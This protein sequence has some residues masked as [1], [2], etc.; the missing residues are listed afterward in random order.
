LHTVHMITLST[1][2][3]AISSAVTVIAHTKDGPSLH[4]SIDVYDDVLLAISGYSYRFTAIISSYK[5][6]PTCS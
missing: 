2:L 6:S 1:L 4:G 5:I 3:V